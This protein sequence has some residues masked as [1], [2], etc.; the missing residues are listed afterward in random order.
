MELRASSSLL[1]N[2][3]PVFETKFLCHSGCPGFQ[4]RKEYK[5]FPTRWMLD[6]G[7]LAHFTSHLKDFLDIQMGNFGVVQTASKLEPMLG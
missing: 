2:I 5:D 3:V 6:S 4:T 7:A 1:D